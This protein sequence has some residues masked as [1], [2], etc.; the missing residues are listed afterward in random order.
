VEARSSRTADSILLLYTVQLL[1]AVE[2]N[3]DACLV[4]RPAVAD[5]KLSSLPC[6]MFVVIPCC[7]T[8]T[9]FT[10]APKAG[11]ALRAG[12]RGRFCVVANFLMLPMPREESVTSHNSGEPHNALL[13]KIESQCSTPV[14]IEWASKQKWIYI[15]RSQWADLVIRGNKLSAFKAVTGI[16]YSICNVVSQRSI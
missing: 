5:G 8:L 16:V 2:F 1:T 12:V 13:R 6:T 4:Y 3:S 7:S 11:Q 14:S 10:I 15:Y 9:L